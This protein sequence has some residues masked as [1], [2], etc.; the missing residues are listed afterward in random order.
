[1]AAVEERAAVDG[2]KL[3]GFVLRAVDEIGATLNTALVVMGDR[4]GFYR[5]LA[6]AGP[7]SGLARPS[8]TS[9]SG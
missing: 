5:A 4:L 8:V 1:V 3:M 6:D 9:A 7:L 2:D